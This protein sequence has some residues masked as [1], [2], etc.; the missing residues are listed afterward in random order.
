MERKITNGTAADAFSPNEECTRAQIA[1]FLWR[2]AGQPEADGDLP[3]ADVPATAYYADAVRWA[4]RQS[5]T[6]G[7]DATHFSPAKACTR[8]EI[9]TFLQRAAA[10]QSS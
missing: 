8:A 10:G 3:F 2:A 5:I 6:R 4:V 9:V 1:A 7:T